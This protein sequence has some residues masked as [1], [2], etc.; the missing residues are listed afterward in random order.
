M[1]RRRVNP[2]AW[3]AVGFVVLLL[4][5]LVRAV[6]GGD[7]YRPAALTLAQ[8]SAALGRE[9]AALR[10]QVRSLDRLELFRR[11]RAWERRSREHTDRSADLDPP[12]ELRR[13]NGFLVTALGLRADALRRL[14]PAVRN[15]LSDQDQQVAGSQLVNVMKDLVFADR[16]WELFRA[17]WPRDADAKPSVSR[18]VADEE[19]AS[20]TEVTD[21]VRELRQQQALKATYNLTISSVTVDPRPAGQ[22]GNVDVVPFTRSLGVSVIVENTGNQQIPATTVAAIL[23]SESDPEPKTV[24]GQLGTMRPKDKKSV[25]LKGIEPTPGVR[26]KLRVT[27]GPVGEERNTLDNTVEY[28]FIMRRP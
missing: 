23:T 22:E 8:Q 4:V 2:V 14:N 6:G 20:I 26:N 18:W 17:S 5:L 25:V 27:V 13:S 19:D 24:E 9:V 21:F 15:A 3:G 12:G 11:L 16:S 1:P 28:D 7:G 10:T